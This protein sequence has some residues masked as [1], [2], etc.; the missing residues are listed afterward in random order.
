VY[1]LILKGTHD[2][3]VLQSLKNKDEGQAA[4]IEALRL[5]VMKK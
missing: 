1:H 3:R 5:E 4:A 2:A